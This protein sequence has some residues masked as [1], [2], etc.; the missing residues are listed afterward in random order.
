MKDISNTLR[1]RALNFS[2]MR[3]SKIFP[4][5]DYRLIE[6]FVR[7]VFFNACNNVEKEGKL[8]NY[9]D[10]SIYKQL[11]GYAWKVILK[12]LD[13]CITILN[14]TDTEKAKETVEYFNRRKA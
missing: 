2:W 13:R 1:L 9:S 7:T 6:P 10:Y 5:C 4:H 11:C 3:F 14:K 12:E 8:E